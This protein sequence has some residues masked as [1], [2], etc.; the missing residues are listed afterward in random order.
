MNVIP[1]V[2]PRGR[3]AVPSDIAS[4]VRFLVS[5]E[6]QHVTGQTWHVNGGQ[7]LY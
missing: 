5:D 7:F 4:V 3:I 6:A 2:P 1:T